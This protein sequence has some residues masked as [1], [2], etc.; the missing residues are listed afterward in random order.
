MVRY[1]RN[2]VPGGTFFF[3]GDA[4]RPAVIRIDRSC[5][6]AARRVPSDAG[7]QSV[8][9]RSHRRL[10]GSFACDLDLA[11]WRRRFSR[12]LEKHQGCVH[13]RC[14]RK[15]HANSARSSWR[16]FALATALLGTHHSQRSGLRTMRELCSFQSGQASPG[17]GAERLAVFVAAP[18]YPRR[19]LATRLGWRRS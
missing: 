8:R 2:L 12:A 5:C 13:T 17:F 14:D 18:I 7:S 1:R 15:R 16:V 11:E 19:D 6:F 4:G 3:Y 9:G 10:A